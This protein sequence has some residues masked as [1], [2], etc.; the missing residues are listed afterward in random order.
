MSNQ[1]T[2]EECKQ[3]FY[4]NR[5]FEELVEEMSET[6]PGSGPETD[7]VELCDPCYQKFMR[8]LQS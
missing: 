8:A 6:F 5:E 1:F 4:R 7:V 3:T 2:C